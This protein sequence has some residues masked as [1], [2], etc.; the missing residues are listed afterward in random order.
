MRYSKEC[1]TNHAHVFDSTV[2]I[3]TTYGPASLTSNPV[4][5]GWGGGLGQPEDDDI[6][7]FPDCERN[8]VDDC[9]WLPIA[10]VPE[11]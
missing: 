3:I 10:D 7:W 11:T 1:N 8:D 4:T 5:V 2:S 6:A 9:G